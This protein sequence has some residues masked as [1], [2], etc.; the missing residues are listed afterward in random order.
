ML[1]FSNRNST[2]T[3]IINKNESKMTQKQNQKT[4]LRNY[5]VT[6]SNVLARAAQRLTL[7]EKRLI[8][9]AISQINPL[10]P[11]NNQDLSFRV[12]AKTFS[13]AFN[14]ELKSVYRDIKQS[15]TS[16]S[17][18]QFTIWSKDEK[19]R[20]EDT[21]NWLVR[22]TYHHGDG[23]VEIEL[24]KYVI[25]HLQGLNSSF[26]SYALIMASKY[27]SAYT[28]RL[29][30][31]ISTMKRQ[32]DNSYNGY[33]VMSTEQLRHAMDIPASYKYAMIKSQILNHSFKEIEINNSIRMKLEEFKT[34][35]KIT[36]VKITFK[37]A[38]NESA[39]HMLFEEFWQYFPRKERKAIAIEFWDKSQYSIAQM[40]SIVVK[41]LTYKQYCTTE[42]ID[43]QYVKKPLNWLSD[44]DWME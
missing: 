22:K 8:Y 40:E 37:Q 28:W 32:S 24:S 3:W 30:E 41:A 7:N 27:K 23:W 39:S 15:A 38:K 13:E 35:R 31:L 2:F 14:L 11:T 19:G 25:S 44:G 9:I 26:S 36:A 10:K 6:Q 21:Y 17:R 4:G 33:L 16:L 34:G 20:I 29:L 18:K 1:E 42:D 5:Q 43:K 12:D